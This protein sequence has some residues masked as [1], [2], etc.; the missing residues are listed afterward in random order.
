[1]QEMSDYY[2]HRSVLAVGKHFVVHIQPSQPSRLLQMVR[3]KQQ[4]LLL[5]LLQRLS[6]PIE[7]FHVLFTGALK[8]KE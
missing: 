3:L 5:E 1:M 4:L 7:R 6:E 8:K 2:L